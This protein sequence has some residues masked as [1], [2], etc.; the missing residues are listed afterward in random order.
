MFNLSVNVFQLRRRIYKGIPNSMRGET[1][2]KLL[3]V[4]NVPN[5]ST[6]YEVHESTVNM[7]YFMFPV[8][9]GCS[10][11]FKGIFTTCGFFALS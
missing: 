10:T 8:I 5:R 6:V 4:E 11:S 3:Q 9:C 1:W 2:K 7:Y